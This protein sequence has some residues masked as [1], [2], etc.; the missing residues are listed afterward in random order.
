LTSVEDF[1][2]ADGPRR[3]SRDDANSA[4]KRTEVLVLF[5]IFGRAERVSRVGVS[6]RRDKDKSAT[7]D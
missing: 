3:P 5:G 7:E 6:T 2:N 4:V 1:V